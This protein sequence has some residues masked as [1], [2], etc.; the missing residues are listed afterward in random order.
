MLRT[1]APHS[2]VPSWS[3]TQ[4]LLT[5]LTV[6][7]AVA[8][9]GTSLYASLPHALGLNRLYKYVPPFNG[10][11]L[12]LLDHLGGEH[13]SIAEALVAGRGFADPFHDRT[14]P[15]AWMAPV[16]PSLQAF[17][18]A[19]GGI[20]LTVIMVAFLQNLTLVFTGWLVMRAA[21][22]C[23]SPRAPAVACILYFATTWSYFSS[24][25]QFTHDAW[26]VMLLVGML[27][28][29]ADR[30]W[31][32]PIGWRS[33]V[34]WGLLGG[35]AA[36]ASPALGLPWLALSVLLGRSSRQI[37]PVFAS[38]LVAG[39]VMAPWI[40]RN[41]IVFGR[42]IPVKSNLPFEFYQSNALEPTGVLR[43]ETCHTHPFQTAGTE[44]SRYV[45]LGEMAYLDE[46]RTRAAEAIRR[47]PVGYLIRVKNRLLAATCVY[48]SFVVGEGRGR[49]LVRSLLYTLPFL[50]LLA[51]VL[52]GRWLRDPLP[53]IALVVFVTYLTPYVLV[54]YYRRYALPLLGLQVMFEIWGLDAIHLF[55]ISRRGKP[56]FERTT[57]SPP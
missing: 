43:D 16:L 42:F 19:L 14:G 36:S 41:A 9:F 13:R 25:Y 27:V 4:R 45:K 52:S 26:L 53:R 56:C 11:D 35:I 1:D 50:G 55:V 12:S 30:L 3:S 6:L 48:Y 44:R 18:L 47:D 5:R 51:M 17:L 23:R 49:V 22:R 33:S 10:Q 40:V 8:V 20:K 37:R 32:R 57:V 39:T 34:G 21:A 29:V 2:S 46:Y 38:I 15:T 7:L 54:A 31:A 28:Y 24:C